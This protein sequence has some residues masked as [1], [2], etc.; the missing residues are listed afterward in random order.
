MYIPFTV[1]TILL[2]FPDSAARCFLNESADLLGQGQDQIW[3]AH[4]TILIHQFADLNLAKTV[5][6]IDD[7][8]R[9]IDQVSG[10]GSIVIYIIR[11]S[12]R[13]IGVQDLDGMKIIFFK[14]PPQMLFEILECY[15]NKTI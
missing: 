5:I 12:E 3:N 2:L 13:G 10:A 14:K 11:A 8:K 4:K 1:M 6:P 15:A 9:D 7:R